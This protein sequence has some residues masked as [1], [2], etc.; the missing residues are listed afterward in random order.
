MSSWKRPKW[1]HGFLWVRNA[2]P[3]TPSAT[4][5]EIAAPLPDVPPSE[6][7]NPIPNLT[8]TTHPHLFKIV[9][10]IKVH[11][12]EQLLSSHPNRPLVGSIC[13]GLREGFWRF[14]IFDESAPQTWD[15]SSRP[16]EGPN[17]EFAL[18]QRDEEI[19]QDRIL[20]S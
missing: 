3:Q 14:A 4:Y 2:S 5:T 18:D 15:N 12:F 8:I 1:S 7:R 19:N 9:T 20:W 6:S 13:C 17:L 11:R 16:L 10:P